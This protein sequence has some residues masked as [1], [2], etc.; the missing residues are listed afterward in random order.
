[1]YINSL[2]LEN[3]RNFRKREFQFHDRLTVLVGNEGSGKT[4]L[5]EVIKTCVK[6]QVTKKINLFG[7]DIAK[8]AS[9]AN[10]NYA[11]VTIDKHTNRSQ[12][13][14][15]QITILDRKENYR[16]RDVQ[17]C[18]IDSRLPHNKLKNFYY[19][20]NAHKNLIGFNYQLDE[21][22]N[23]EKI[24]LFLKKIFLVLENSIELKKLLETEVQYIRQE[25]LQ[26]YSRFE[27]AYRSNEETKAVSLL[28]KESYYENLPEGFIQTIT[29]IMAICFDLVVCI[30]EENKENQSK[31]NIFEAPGIMLLDDLENVIHESCHLLF[32]EMFR[33][34][35]PYI[36][37][38]ITTKKDLKIDAIEDKE[39][40]NL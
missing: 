2:N 32:L 27:K 4:N 24:T 15:Y 21:L 36:Q 34:L 40:I 30:E 5:L 10:I 20:C 3:Y 33:E 1:M 35:F 23:K 13:G 25:L 39:V 6:Y 38:I 31:E 11:I 7:K 9:D 37:L 28:Q 16:T 17:F 29:N 8:D 19:Y 12:L 26:Q 14:E 22:E 18:D